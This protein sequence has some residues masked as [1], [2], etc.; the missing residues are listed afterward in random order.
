[1]N[2]DERKKI[3][4]NLIDVF[5]KAGEISLHSDALLHGSDPNNSNRPRCGITFRYSPS[6]VKA[7]LSE[8]PFFSIQVA[9]GE[10]NHSL[11]PIAPI[12]RGEA[13]PVK[14]FQFHHEFE[15]EW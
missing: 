4:D 7:N 13:T 5:L 3:V 12:P 14:G 1:M 6:N 9:R 10:T 2:L 11:N 8:W 15:S